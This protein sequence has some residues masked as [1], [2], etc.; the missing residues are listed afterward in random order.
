VKQIGIKAPNRTQSLTAGF[1]AVAVLL[2]TIGHHLY[3]AFLYD[4]PW[5]AHMAH[6]G[7]MGIIG[8]VAAMSIVWRWEGTPIGRAGLWVFTMLTV[9]FPIAWIGLFE[10]G[11][12]HVLKN[13]LYL[14]G[15]SPDRMRVLFPPPTYEPP[16]DVLFELTGVLQFFLALV[17]IRA[18][19]PLVRGLVGTRMVT[20]GHTAVMMLTAA[21]AS[22]P[23]GVSIAGPDLY[24]ASGLQPVRQGISAPDFSLHTLDGRS[25]AL[26]SL[27]GKVV[28][29]NFWATWC[30]PCKDEMP[31]LQRLKESFKTGE[32]ELLAIT[33]DAQREAIARFVHSLGLAFPILLDETKDVSAAFGV[34][35]LPTT[36]LIERDGRLLAR[37]VGPRAW[38]SPETIALIRTVLE[39]A[40]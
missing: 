11:Y 13:A 6:L 40:P 3:G 1:S 9:A 14:G 18:I 12:N 33:T 5:R 22:V 28:V 8:I 21:L 16:N 30:G 23:V 2:L 19:S 39:Q 34:R 15:L 25:L 24:T 27:R 29:L 32:F 17:T 38:D 31:S 10:G 36:V 35:G 7:A 4:T 37:A 20:Q 26:S